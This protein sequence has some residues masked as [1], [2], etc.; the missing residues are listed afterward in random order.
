MLAETMRYV[1]SKNGLCDLKPPAML[2]RIEPPLS[3][4]KA[5]F[6]LTYR[7]EPP[8]IRCL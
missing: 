2:S 3:L 1:G 7:F 5:C 6:E 4:I 8:V